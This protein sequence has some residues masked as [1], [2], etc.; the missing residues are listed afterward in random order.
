MALCFD[1]DCVHCCSLSILTFLKAYST[2]ATKTPVAVG[3][4]LRFGVAAL[5]VGAASGL[6]GSIRAFYLRKISDKNVS[7]NLSFMCLNMGHFIM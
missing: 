5:V 2:S 4:L 6:C 7:L 1:V 3:R